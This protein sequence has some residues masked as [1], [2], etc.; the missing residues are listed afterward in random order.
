MFES[1]GVT[2]TDITSSNYT[3]CFMTYSWNRLTTRA[4]HGA[5]DHN[6]GVDKNIKGVDYVIMDYLCG[7]PRDQGD[8][9][10][11]VRSTSTKPPAITSAM[12]TLWELVSQK[13]EFRS[14]ESRWGN[15]NSVSSPGAHILD[16][17]EPLPDRCVYDP[18][19]LHSLECAVKRALRH[20]HADGSVTSDLEKLQEWDVRD[21]GEGVNLSSENWVRHFL[22]NIWL[23]K[24]AR[25]LQKFVQTE[26]IGRAFMFVPADTAQHYQPDNRGQLTR[27][28]GSRVD[29]SLIEL[30]SEGIVREFWQ[31]IIH[32]GQEEVRLDWDG[33][34]RWDTVD[35][36]LIKVSAATA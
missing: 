16:I 5:F 6:V 35:K 36:I 26:G 22:E 24:A 19:L 10:E 11:L 17:A 27:I 21:Y 32:R 33:K 13:L 23:K 34:G 30:K 12:A 28:D 7:K 29:V 3:K 18:Q 14:L 1:R 8:L 9:I 2:A 20:I 4:K 25:I 15:Q 31:D